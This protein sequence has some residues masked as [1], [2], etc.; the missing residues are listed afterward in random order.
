MN[1]NKP[2]YIAFGVMAILLLLA[3]VA[4]TL[5]GVPVFQN[6]TLVQ[7]APQPM[8]EPTLQEKPLFEDPDVEIDTSS[9]VESL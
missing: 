6:Q 9:S 7:P 2:W 8:F 3:V 4:M 5:I 1:E